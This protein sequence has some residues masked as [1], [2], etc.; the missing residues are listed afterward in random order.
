M[1][2]GSSLDPGIEEFINTEYERLIDGK[3]REYLTLSEILRIEPPEQYPFD[4][5]HVGNLYVLDKN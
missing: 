3:D 4:F 1:G 2:T 5:Y